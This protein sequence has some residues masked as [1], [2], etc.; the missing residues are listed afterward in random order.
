MGSLFVVLEHPPVGRLADIVE[1]GE[2]AMVQ[3]LVTEGPIEALDVGVL[4]GLAGLD[5]L[6]GQAVALGPLDE[7]FA[8]RNSGPLSV[9]STCGKPWLLLSCSKMRTKRAELIDVST[10][11]CSTSRLKSSTTLK[12][13]NRRP[14]PLQAISSGWNG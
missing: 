5:V 2:Q 13:R 14:Q 3:D 9:R 11:M 8:P 1:A 12:V 10:S 7:G 4:V 6:D